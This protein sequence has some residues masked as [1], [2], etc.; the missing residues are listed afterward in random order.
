MSFLFIDGFS[1][2]PDIQSTAQG[3]QSCWQFG[4]NFSGNLTLISGRFGG[5]AVRVADASVGTS[6]YFGQAVA[7][8]ST[9]AIGCAYR[10]VGPNSPPGVSAGA[11]FWS[12]L[13]GTKLCGWGINSNQ[14]L[15]LWVGAETNAVATFA[16]PLPPG[17]WHYV[18]ME[19]HILASGGVLNLYL[20]GIEVATFTGVV[21]ATACTYISFGLNGNF[22][23]SVFTQDYGDIYAVNV[24]TRVGECQ[25][26]P[27]VPNSDQQKQWTPLTGSTNYPMVDTLPCDGDA[28]Y[29]FSNTANQEDLYGTAGLPFTPVSIFAV[30]VRVAARKDDS[31]TRTMATSLSSGGTLVHGTTFAVSGSYQ[32]QRDIYPTD[33]HTSAAWLQAGV[34]A[35]QIGQKVIS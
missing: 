9:F 17:G 27:L 24:A 13:N 31:A 28:A 6:G 10:F 15:F 32:Y 20:D 35:A 12:A 19:A 21:S 33:P 22:V 8:G 29:V 2:Y 16:T 34:N 18:E 23:S 4:S 30:Q 5:Q 3:L 1:A 7:S 11:T 14:Q 26:V 25:V